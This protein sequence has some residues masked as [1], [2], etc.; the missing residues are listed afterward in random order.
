MEIIINSLLENKK[1]SGFQTYSD[2]GRSNS[3]TFS[4]G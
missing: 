2:E 1:V 3:A 4:Q